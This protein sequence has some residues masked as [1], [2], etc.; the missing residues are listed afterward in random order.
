MHKLDNDLENEIEEMKEKNESLL[1]EK[2]SVLR[3]IKNENQRNLKLENDYTQLLF[4]L[5][6]I[7][8]NSRVLRNKSE[9][10]EN[11]IY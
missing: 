4:H 7:E 5:K 10:L 8:E 3:T 9:G 6:N 2:E 1:K 11:Q